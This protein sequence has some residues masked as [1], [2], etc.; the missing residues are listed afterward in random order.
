MG[1]NEQWK[2]IQFEGIHT[3]FNY[4]IS[5]RGNL[6]RYDNTS[7]KYRKLKPSL[8]K[9]YMVY[10]FRSD[11]HWKKK[12][13]KTIHRLVAE[14]FLEKDNHLQEFVIHKDY[15]KSNNVLE[16]LM[17]VTKETLH[18]HHKLNP[19]YKNPPKGIIRYSKLS[20]DKVKEIKRLLKAGEQKPAQI[21]RQFGI[22]HTQLNR[23]K[24][25]EN[26]AH[27]KID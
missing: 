2:K 26:W 27:I 7:G 23:I 25:G 14:Y 4:E 18:A 24:N 22:T 21:A 13:T 6:R 17:W 9:G 8:F 12:H 15:D 3:E 11:G 19:N 10:S 5:N 1:N 20:P 16:N